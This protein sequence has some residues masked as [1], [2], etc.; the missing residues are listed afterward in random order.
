MT[1]KIAS[2]GGTVDFDAKQGLAKIWFHYDQ[3]ANVNRDSLNLSSVTDNSFGD[4][5]ANINSN[6]NNS[7]YATSH[8]GAAE[9][10]PTDT[11]HLGTTVSFL[12]TTA[13]NVQTPSHGTTGPS[14]DDW[15]ENF[16]A[17]HGDLA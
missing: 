13:F 1:I 14:Q 15:P 17:T 6:M 12:T 5:N 4:F 10:S 9:E 11:Q 7:N 8:S 16:C 3:I 2:E